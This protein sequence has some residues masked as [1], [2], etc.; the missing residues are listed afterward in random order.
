MVSTQRKNPDLSRTDGRIR[1]F[2]ILSTF[3]PLVATALVVLVVHRHSV[4]LDSKAKLNRLHEKSI[5]LS[6]ATAAAQEFVMLRREAAMGSK[7]ISREM[8]EKAEEE[9][10]QLLTSRPVSGDRF[11]EVAARALFDA[12]QAAFEIPTERPTTESALWSSVE[13]VSRAMRALFRLSQITLADTKVIQQRAASVRARADDATR[14]LLVEGTIALLLIVAIVSAGLLFAG[15]ELRR[16]RR[17]EAELHASYALVA[18]AASLSG[19]GTWT[20][21]HASGNVAWSHIEAF[22][23]NDLG[24]TETKSLEDFLAKIHPGDAGALRSFIDRAWES[25]YSFATEVRLMT[26]N[27]LLREIFVAGEPVPSAANEE[28]RLMGAFMDVTER[29]EW[30]RLIRDVEDRFKI[31]CENASSGVII[32]GPNGF[33]EYANN[34]IQQL[35]GNSFAQADKLWTDFISE[36]DR[37]VMITVLRRTLEHERIAHIDVDWQAENGRRLHTRCVVA[38]LFDGVRSR[39]HMIL[40]DDQTERRNRAEYDSLLAS[41]V[42]R[43]GCSVMITDADLRILYVNP[44]HRELTGYLP[45]EVIGSTPVIFQ[46]PETD[47]EARIQIR[48]AIAER[49][50]AMVEMLNYRPDGTP[51]W[52]HLSISAVF[53]NE[54]ELTHFVAFKHDITRRK[55]LERSLARTISLT[56]METMELDSTRV[57]LQKA[58]EK[59]DALAMTDELTGIANQRRFNQ[60]IEEEYHRVLRTRRPFSVLMIDVDHFKLFNDRFGHLAGDDVLRL[61]ALA[62]RESLR[63]I[64]L[65]ARYGGEEFVALL[66]ETDLDQAMRAAE[67]AR[68]AVEGIDFGESPVTI[69]VGVAEFQIGKETVRDLLNRADAALYRAKNA[70]RNRSAPSYGTNEISSSPD[71]AS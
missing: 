63:N 1:L 5:W 53:D 2:R 13:S 58:N 45:D 6:S 59:L 62:I 70:G 29:N 3:A 15:S 60:K 35:L 43:A 21:D 46:G 14:H 26:P 8:L 32:L 71:L 4:V 39:G 9:L 19:L 12:K 23:M 65:I 68:Q 24:L 49:K 69:S 57:R 48:E 56:Q 20:V 67:R 7:A 41:V 36:S 64:D 33:V 28:R 42:E 51:Y 10:R 61:T 22:D 38:P 40:V 16:R 44:A 30:R 11:T 52:I 47:I 66:P 18:S 55:E 25:G 37:D 34:V 31:I 54:G 17:S 50:P 27:G